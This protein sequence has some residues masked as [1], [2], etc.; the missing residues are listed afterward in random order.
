[1]V[2]LTA[3]SSENP[4]NLTGTELIAKEKNLNLVRGICVPASCSQQKV[5]QYANIKFVELHA[6]TS[7]CKTNDPVPFKAIDIFAM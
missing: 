5:I 7:V 1:M 4:E 3:N 6:I 2:T